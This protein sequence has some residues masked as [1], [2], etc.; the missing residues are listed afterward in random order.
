MINYRMKELNVHNVAPDI[1]AAAADDD[2]VSMY[3]IHLRTYTL[4]LQ[5]TMLRRSMYRQFRDLGVFVDFDNEG[6]LAS[7]SPRG[8]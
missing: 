6:V 8:V 4:L 3:I 5:M 7:P 1:D 2:A